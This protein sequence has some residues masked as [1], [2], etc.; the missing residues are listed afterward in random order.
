MILLFFMFLLFF[1]RRHRQVVMQ[2]GASWVVLA[3]LEFVSTYACI[4]GH[5]CN[6][7]K[8]GHHRV[9]MA[10]QSCSCINDLRYI[11]L[12]NTKV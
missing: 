9:V 3:S 12:N 11:I 4:L 6:Q 1:F 7:A 8:N 10:V 5:T 2:L